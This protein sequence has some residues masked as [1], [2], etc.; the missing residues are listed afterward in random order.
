MFARSGFPSAVIKAM[1]E[2]FWHVED[3]IRQAKIVVKA[4]TTGIDHFI[5]PKVL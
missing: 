2:A 5:S 3:I 4:N 1:S